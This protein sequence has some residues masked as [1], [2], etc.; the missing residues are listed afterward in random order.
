M[1]ILFGTKV[2]QIDL[3]KLIHTLLQ[4]HKNISGFGCKVHLKIFAKTSADFRV[5]E[6]I[7]GRILLFYTEKL[8]KIKN[9]LQILAKY[10]LKKI[11][12]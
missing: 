7:K 5:D 6:S 4:T 11:N 10:L 8:Q 12:K 3:E 9:I 2:M 1:I